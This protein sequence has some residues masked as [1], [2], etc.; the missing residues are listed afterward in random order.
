MSKSS[1]FLLTGYSAQT[2]IYPIR[3]YQKKVIEVLLKV[4]Y[5]IF[6]YTDGDK[7]FNSDQSYFRRAG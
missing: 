2:N 5:F 4:K 7:G 3:A 1:S 6:L